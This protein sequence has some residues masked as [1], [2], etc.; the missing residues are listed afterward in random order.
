MLLFDDFVDQEPVLLPGSIL[1][2]EAAFLGRDSA[3]SPSWSI[4][5]SRIMAKLDALR[6]QSPDHAERIN[7]EFMEAFRAER[8]ARMERVNDG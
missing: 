2:N 3:A 6:R 4:S 1:L 8:I 5:Q 7:E